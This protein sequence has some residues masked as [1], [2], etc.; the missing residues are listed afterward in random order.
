MHGVLHLDTCC[1]PTAWIGHVLGS[2]V[3]K[4]GGGLCLLD[5]EIII[6]GEGYWDHRHSAGAGLLG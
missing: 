6:R 4:F 5:T 1:Q 3:R 2:T